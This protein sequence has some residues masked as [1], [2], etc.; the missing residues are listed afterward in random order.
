M[1]GLFVFL[2]IFAVLIGV[3]AWVFHLIL[4]DRRGPKDVPYLELPGFPLYGYNILWEIHQ[5]LP[6]ISHSNYRWEVYT[7]KN[8]L[9]NLV[10]VNLLSLTY[11]KQSRSVTSID[12]SSRRYNMSWSSLRG[13][14]SKFMIERVKENIIAPMLQD[15]NLVLKQVGLGTDEKK[16]YFIV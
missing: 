8:G 3:P 10:V 9:R 5:A 2:G 6:D 13:C 15:V 16:N 11:G 4:K 14:G 1:A 12:I 7:E